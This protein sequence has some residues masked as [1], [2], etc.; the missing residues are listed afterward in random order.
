M[1]NMNRTVATT[2]FPFPNPRVWNEK[3]K[4]VEKPKGGR[5]A[6]FE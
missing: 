6:A 2:C 3:Q 5:D 1:K 4:E